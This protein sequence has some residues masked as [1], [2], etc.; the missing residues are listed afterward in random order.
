MREGNV[1]PKIEV[2]ATCHTRAIGS[3]EVP[4]RGFGRSCLALD[5]IIAIRIQIA[6][7]NRK[8]GFL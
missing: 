5:K 8:Q 2:C 4:A 1:P 7:N 6:I 3:A